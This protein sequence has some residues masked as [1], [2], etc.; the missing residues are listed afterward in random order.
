M[1]R[2]GQKPLAF[3]R[4]GYVWLLGS[5]AN[6]FRVPF[7]ERLVLNQSPPPHTLPVAIDALEAFGVSTQARTVKR[8][9]QLKRLS[10]PALAIEITP[11]GKPHARLRVIHP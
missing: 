3:S 10:V 9:G 5:I 6:L 4:E 1:F 2:G 8:G 7:D 11:P